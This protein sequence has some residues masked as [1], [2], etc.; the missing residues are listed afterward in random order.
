MAHFSADA[1]Q[2]L[3]HLRKQ[4]HRAPRKPGRHDS[5]A[6][7]AYNLR[8]VAA[9]VNTGQL[10][11]AGYLAEQLHADADFTRRY[12]SPFGRTAAAVYREQ[13]GTEAPETGLDVR[14][15]RLVRVRAYTTAVLEKAAAKYARTANLI[16]A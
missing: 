3:G 7:R 6:R 9:R 4:P 14:G 15:K 8:Q 16:G 1:P 11:A 5:P 10:T 12:S 2:M 13:Y